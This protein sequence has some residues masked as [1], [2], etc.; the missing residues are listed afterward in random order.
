M[1][2]NI[3][4][5]TIGLALFAVVLFGVSGFMG[6]LLAN[7][8]K[9]PTATEQAILDVS[10]IDDMT[11]IGN[12]ANEKLNGTEVDTTAADAELAVNPF[13]TLRIFF[14]LPEVLDTIIDASARSIGLDPNVRFIFYAIGLFGFIFALIN[15]F[16]KVS[17]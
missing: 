5:M 8:G 15:T 1:E 3:K 7:Y 10:L 2:D 14:A 6:S 11:T 17:T 4:N 13:N 9:T 16:T 12:Q